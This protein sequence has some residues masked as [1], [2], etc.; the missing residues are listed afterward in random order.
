MGF[1]FSTRG[2][3]Y[4][5]AVELA[6]GRVLRESDV[7][8]DDVPAGA[9]VRKLEIVHLRTGVSHVS[10][11]DFAQFFFA[12]EAEGFLTVGGK[13]DGRQGLR[14][15]AKIFGGIS[16]DGT[17]TEARMTFDAP[18]LPRVSQRRYGFDGFPYV[19]SVLRPGAA[20]AGA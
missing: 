17:V 7:T 5:F 18:G 15:V 12:N 16:R 9:A 3:E 13:H 1:A 2:G 19:Q 4:G 20:S 8:W 10:I 6:D 11:S 14:H